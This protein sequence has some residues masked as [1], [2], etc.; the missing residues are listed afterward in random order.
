GAE[1]ESFGVGHA[2]VS[3]EL[4]RGWR[5]P[6]DVVE[7]IRHHHRPS[8]IVN[9]GKVRHGRAELL[10]LAGHLIQLDAV[11][12]N[13]ELLACLLATARRPRPGVARP[14]AATAAG[15]EADDAA[16]VPPAVRRAA[17]GGRV[18]AGELRAAE[19]ARPRGDGRGVQ[20]VRAEPAAVRGGQAARAG[21]GRV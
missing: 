2:E 9:A 19:V 14:A 1:E 10:E 7:P 4:L 18:P 3:A 8:A 20:G 15:G 12:Q 16:R 17:A 21:A 13:A 11:A 5:L 6:D